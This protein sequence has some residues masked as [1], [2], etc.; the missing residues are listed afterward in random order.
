MVNQLRLVL[1]NV[2]A[3][4]LDDGNCRIIVS[5][6]RKGKV[7]TGEATSADTEEKQMDAV[8]LA[9]VEAIR[10]LLSGPVEMEVVYSKL[11]FLTGI[12]KV[13]FLVIIQITEPSSAHFVPGICLFTTGTLEVAA[14]ATLNAL[15]RNVAKYMI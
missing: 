12:T 14:R 4:P 15:N 9:T 10:K 13:I 8:A 5:I 7:Y 6:E 1:K 11:I 2:E 3:T